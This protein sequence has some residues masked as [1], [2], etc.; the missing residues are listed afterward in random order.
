MCMVRTGKHTDSHI[1][2]LMVNEM[3]I[4]NRKS[5]KFFHLSKF[6][7]CQRIC[8]WSINFSRRLLFFT[9]FFVETAVIM[10]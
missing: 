5:K 8:V 4:Y 2:I 10:Q 6:F 9:S 1:N 3:P 7:N